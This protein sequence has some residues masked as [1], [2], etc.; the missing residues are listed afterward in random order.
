MITPKNPVLNFSTLEEHFGPFRQWNKNEKSL[1]ISL[2]LSKN[3]WQKSGDERI[4]LW[5]GK[6]YKHTVSTRYMKIFPYFYS[7]LNH[8]KILVSFMF[9]LKLYLTALLQCTVWNTETKESCFLTQ[10]LALGSISPST[11][12]LHFFQ[13]CHMLF[14]LLPQHSSCSNLC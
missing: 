4:W 12:H 2:F 6:R 9:F 7:T 3:E 5:K 13:P 1:I 8:R 10:R 14:Q 11:Y